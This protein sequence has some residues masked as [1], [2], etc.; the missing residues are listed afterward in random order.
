VDGGKT[1]VPQ[2]SASFQGAGKWAGVVRFVSEKNGFVFEDEAN[3][4]SLIYSTDGGVNWHK[5][6][7]PHGVFDC[8]VFEGDL[9]CSSGFRQSGFRL[10]SLHLE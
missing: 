1:W 4:H 3:R 8:Q 9:L 2:A 5:Q 10:L 6:P 7:L